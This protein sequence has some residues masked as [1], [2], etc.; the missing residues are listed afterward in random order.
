MKQRQ[1]TLHPLVVSLYTMMLDT[2]PPPSTFFI[3]ATRGTPGP[4]ATMIV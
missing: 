3:D 4:A 2:L 1:I